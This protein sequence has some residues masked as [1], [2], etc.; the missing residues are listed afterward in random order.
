[1]SAEQT[2]C[3][4]SSSRVVSDTVSTTSARRAFTSSCFQY[5]S[6][7]FGLGKSVRQCA[8]SNELWSV[9]TSGHGFQHG[10]P[11]SASA[12]KTSMPSAR[13][14]RGSTQSFQSVSRAASRRTTCARTPSRWRRQGSSRANTTSSTSSRRDNAR[15]RFVA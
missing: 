7:R 14:R 4:I 1:L 9:T 2:R 12:W 10:S 3:Q 15:S 5:Q 13:R 11:R 8:R 6:A